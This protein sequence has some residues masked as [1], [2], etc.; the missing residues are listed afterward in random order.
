[1]VNYLTIKG[2]YSLHTNGVMR[3]VNPLFMTKYEVIAVNQYHILI[4][5]LESG[6]LCVYGSIHIFTKSFSKYNKSIE[7]NFQLCHGKFGPF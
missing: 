3:R 7:L 1:M 6:R 2:C 5:I 4:R